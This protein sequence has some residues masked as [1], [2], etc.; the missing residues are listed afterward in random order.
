MGPSLS[1]DAVRVASLRVGTSLDIL[2]RRHVEERSL[3]AKL[4]AGALVLVALALFAQLAGTD[5]RAGF[6]VG[7]PDLMPQVIRGVLARPT[8]LV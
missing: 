3:E 8:A 4:A 7:R 2:V 1:A 6:G 5:V